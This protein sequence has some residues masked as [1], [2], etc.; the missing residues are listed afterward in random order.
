M[1]FVVGE[2]LWRL[3]RQHQVMCVTHLSQLA[4]FGDGHFKVQKQV[5][6]ER[7]LTMVERLDDAGRVLE[8]AQMTGSTSD[9]NRTAAQETLTS[10]RSRQ[11]AIG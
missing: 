1:G 4:A 3:G 9:T 2:K 7:T 11:A 8:L 10:A 6:D 5:V